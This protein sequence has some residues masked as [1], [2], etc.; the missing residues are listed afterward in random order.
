[1]RVGCPHRTGLRPAPAGVALAHGGTTARPCRPGCCP[2]PAA[3]AGWLS[4]AATRSCA[5]RGPVVRRRA[6]DS[7]QGRYSTAAPLKAS[8]GIAVVSSRVQALSASSAAG[9]GSAQGFDDGH[10]LV[11]AHDL[12]SGDSKMSTIQGF[13]RK[14]SSGPYATSDR[15]GEKGCF[16]EPRDILRGVVLLSCPLKDDDNRAWSFGIS[17]APL[18]RGRARRSGL[19][20]HATPAQTRRQLLGGTHARPPGRGPDPFPTQGS[21]NVNAS[22]EPVA[23]ATTT[24]SPTGAR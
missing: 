22:R 5:T 21:T 8:R 7:G 17:P 18:M 3:I 10:A 24:A 16:R 13:N 14:R 6:G 2:W 20:P 4:R 23:R 9:I 19:L 1:M 15:W 12:P 11:R